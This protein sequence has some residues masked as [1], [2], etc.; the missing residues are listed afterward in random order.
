MGYESPKHIAWYLWLIHEHYAD[1]S[2]LLIVQ[3]HRQS[4]QFGS[5]YWMCPTLHLHRTNETRSNE[6][7]FV[8]LV[9]PPR[10]LRFTRNS[11]SD[12]LTFLQFVCLCILGV[13]ALHLI[14]STIIEIILKWFSFFSVFGAFGFILLIKW[15]I[16]DQH[17]DVFWF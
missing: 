1:C 7:N 4:I 17:H 8:T 13:V 16:S 9:R 2:H 6:N 14:V 10:I 3:I 15:S 12:R 5:D 11:G